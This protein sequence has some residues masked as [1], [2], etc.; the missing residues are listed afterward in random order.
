MAVG[1]DDV[2]REWRYN[3]LVA[4]T[5]QSPIYKD[6]NNFYT[7]QI[8]CVNLLLILLVW[9]QKKRLHNATPLNKTN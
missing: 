3:T 2:S 1:N 8:I 4:D 9:V 5:R 6:T 7:T